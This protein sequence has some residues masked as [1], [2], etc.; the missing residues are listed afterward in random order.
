[1]PTT[2][3]AIIQED[4][5][6][7]QLLSQNYYELQIAKGVSAHGRESY[8]V[9]YSSKQLG[10]S[11]SVSWNTSY[12]L[13]WT[14][15]QPS[16]GMRVTLAGQWKQCDLGASYNLNGYGDWDSNHNDPNAKKNCL[17]VG[18]NDF[19]TAVHIII[20]VQ[21]SWSGDWTPIWLDMNSLQ[22]HAHGQY[23]PIET[24]RL[25]YQEGGQTGTIISDEGMPSQEF[26]MTDSP[27]TYFSYDVSEGRWKNPQS[28]SFQ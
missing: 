14:M 2:Y 17:N 12:A 10:P 27:Q 15:E 19:Q 9:V 6:S 24:V 3:K 16:P 25:W 13:N 22:K 23:E 18:S 20:G 4:N 1:M 7:L 5:A 11:I 26:N 28:T 21:D 8:N